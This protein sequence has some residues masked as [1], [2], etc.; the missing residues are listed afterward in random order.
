M[1][2][3]RRERALQLWKWWGWDSYRDQWVSQEKTWSIPCQGQP[4]WF[5]NYASQWLSISAKP[6]SSSVSNDDLPLPTKGHWSIHDE[7]RRKIDGIRS[8]IWAIQAYSTLH[9][10]LNQSTF[11]S[12][13][14]I[15]NPGWSK[16][17]CS[18]LTLG[19]RFDRRVLCRFE[20]RRWAERRI[21]S[22]RLP[23]ENQWQKLHAPA[24]SQVPL[25]HPEPIL[26]WLHWKHIKH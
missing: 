12:Y 25:V 11:P 19:F 5:I 2:L 3:N 17:D 15:I 6:L 7:R 18:R 14:A 23:Q 9:I 21:Q 1:V 10:R 16:K 8:Q 4:A 24:L 13:R 26:P 20:Y 22:C